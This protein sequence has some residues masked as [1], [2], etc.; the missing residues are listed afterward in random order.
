METIWFSI[1][2]FEE[3]LDTIVDETVKQLAKV[4]HVALNTA[5]SKMLNLT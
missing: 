3:P 5:I 4:L 2:I 1:V